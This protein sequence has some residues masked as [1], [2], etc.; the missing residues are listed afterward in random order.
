MCFRSVTCFTADNKQNNYSVFILI[1]ILLNSN[2][3]RT[4][5]F[6]LYNRSY[7]KS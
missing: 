3:E 7:Y 2:T 4:A 5:D 1:T 6:K